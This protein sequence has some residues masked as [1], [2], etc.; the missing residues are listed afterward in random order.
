MPVHKT[1]TSGLLVELWTQSGVGVWKK[2][3]EAAVLQTVVRLV[4]CGALVC[5][6][7]AAD[8]LAICVLVLLAT[9]M[10]CSNTWCCRVLSAMVSVGILATHSFELRTCFAVLGFWAPF[11]PPKGSRKRT[12]NQLCQF[13]HAKRAI[14]QARS[15]DSVF[16]RLRTRNSHGTDNKVEKCW[17]SWMS[18]PRRTTMELNVM[19]ELNELVNAGGGGGERTI[20]PN[21]THTKEEKCCYSWM[22]DPKRTTTELK[23]MKEL[24]NKSVK[25]I[26]KKEEECCCIWM[27]D[28]RR[29]TTE[30]KVMKELLD[31]SVNSEGGVGEKTLAEEE[32]KSKV[33][34]TYEPPTPLRGKGIRFKVASKES[35]RRH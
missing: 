33:M 18:D 21:G 30:L 19:K 17:Y 14:L 1:H 34:E 13:V 15:G 32:A 28:P 4:L 35:G 3:Q 10:H 5:R 12:S 2:L 27:N 20:S 31:K 9:Q 24:L 29:T 25:G 16:K 8:P 23:A 7:T 6:C 22:N 11:F 26:D